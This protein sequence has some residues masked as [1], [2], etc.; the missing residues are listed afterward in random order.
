[1]AAFFVCIPSNPLAIAA[2]FLLL[3]VHRFYSKH[4]I[5]L[6]NCCCRYP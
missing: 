3:P 6:I 2:A 1:M 5:K 4:I